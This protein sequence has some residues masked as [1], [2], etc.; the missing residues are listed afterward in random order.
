M[1]SRGR[2]FKLSV[3]SKIKKMNTSVNKKKS[4]EAPIA[5]Y[6]EIAIIHALQ[7]FDPPLNFIVARDH[8]DVT[9]Y[10]YISSSQHEGMDAC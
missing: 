10:I 2:D 1:G 8:C 5:V 3:K 7:M 6:T 4:S 9:R